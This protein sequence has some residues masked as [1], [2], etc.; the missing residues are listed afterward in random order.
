[1]KSRVQ[2]TRTSAFAAELRR[3]GLRTPEIA[4][5]MRWT[6]EEVVADLNR[7]RRAPPG[8]LPVHLH[9]AAVRR[10]AWLAS[11]RLCPI[12]NHDDLRQEGYLAL[13]LAHRQGRVPAEE[14]HAKRY[15]VRRAL[16]AM[17]DANRSAWRHS[18]PS[19]PIKLDDDDER[20]GGYHEVIDFSAAAERHAQ[21]KQAIERIVLR[22]TPQ[23]IECLDRLAD[24][25]SCTEVAAAMQ[26]DPARVSQLRKKA[27]Q[28]A[29]V[30][31]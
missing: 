11:R 27:R 15:V 6:H 31:L 14:I 5:A 23:L 25:T 16:G 18:P 19:P 29:A 13:M 1:M 17:V 21:I 9:H 20:P 22:G 26:V 8:E 3:C 28:I 30:C 24:G 12:L 10:C 7:A 4:L 2:P